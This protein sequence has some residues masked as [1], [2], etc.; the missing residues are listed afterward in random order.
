MT[1]DLKVDIIHNRIGLHVV[2]DVIHCTMS[3]INNEK[4]AQIH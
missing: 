1:Y 4:L 3:S 2:T